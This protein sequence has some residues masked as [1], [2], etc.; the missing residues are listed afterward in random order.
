MDKRIEKKLAAAGWKVG[1]YAAFLDLPRED[2]ELIELRAALAEALRT[3]RERL[4]HTQ[5]EV[6]SRI[7]SS[8]SRVAKMEAGDPSVSIDLLVRALLRLGATRAQVG[9][10]MGRKRLPARSLNSAVK[11][12]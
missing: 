3:Y 9:K 10:W 11:N 1:D 4:D 5:A 12:R 7:G 6:A 2:I 8:Q